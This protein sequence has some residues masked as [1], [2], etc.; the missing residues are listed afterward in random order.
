MSEASSAPRLWL[1]PVVQV[2]VFGEPHV[3]EEASTNGPMEQILKPS[4]GIPPSIGNR[5]TV[6]ED[7]ETQLYLMQFSEPATFV[8]GNQAENAGQM[9]VKVGRSNDPKRRLGELNG[10]F[11]DAAVFGWKLVQTLRA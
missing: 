2:N 11:P 9:L 8:L 5:Q 6:I 3:E 1:D 7:G 4:R 10:G